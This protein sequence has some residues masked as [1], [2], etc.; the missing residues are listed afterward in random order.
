MHSQSGDTYLKRP[1]EM[2]VLQ[3]YRQWM[4]GV[5]TREASYLNDAWN[6]F[7]KTLGVK[8]ARTAM[9]AMTHF[10]RTLGLCSTCPLK[11]FEPECDGLCRD[12][13]LVLGLISGLQYGDEEAVNFCLSGLSCP[14][15]CD[16]VA[17]A[18][19]VFA[20]SL[21]A[22]GFVLFPL[23]ASVLSQTLDRKMPST[24]LH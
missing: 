18:A 14:N 12:E 16:E 1:A 21:K 13:C 11:T 22:S 15:R 23:P 6:L 2:L 8:K 19:G 17:F 4:M 5:I 24:T 10:V 9:D 20:L 7:A 3:G